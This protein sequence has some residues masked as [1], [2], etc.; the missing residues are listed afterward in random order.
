LTPAGSDSLDPAPLT[1]L[2]IDHGE[3]RIGLALK[4][5]G[6]SLVL[7]I[8]II[9]ADPP[10]DAMKKIREII[11]ERA[12]ALVVVGLPVNEDPRQ[13]LIV[14]RFTRKLRQGISGVRWRF[15]DET[16]TSESARQSSHA[17]SKSHR[18]IDDRAAALILE[19]FLQSHPRIAES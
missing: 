2:A 12:V 15:I 18:P 6:Q 9:D 19:T 14:K 3:K 1:I 5:A 8:A 13:A 7:P 4:P 11:A 10:A 16:L 17:H